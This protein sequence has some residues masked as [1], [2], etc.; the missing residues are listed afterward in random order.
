MREARLQAFEHL[1]I[2]QYSAQYAEDRSIVPNDFLLTTN[3]NRSVL[4][5]GEFQHF[6]K[7]PL[8]VDILDQLYEA[9]TDADY[10]IYSNVDIALQPLFYNEVSK[11]IDDGHDAFVINRRTIP[12][13]YKHINQIPMMLDES[14]TRHR[15]WDCFVFDRRLYPKFKLFHV[16]VG[17]TRVGLALLANLQAYA[18]NFRVFKDEHLTFHIGDERNWLNPVYA[19]YDKYNTREVMRILEAIEAEIGPFKRDSIPGSFLYRKRTLGPLY[20]Y[21]ARHVYLPM[22]LSQALNRLVGRHQ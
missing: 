3:L 14:G 20:E 22:G 4:D 11:F 17:A 1:Q 7:L 13:R 8:L 5:M 18:E 12:S 21:W 19:D 15:G 6:R 10:L 16:C 9:A 2:N